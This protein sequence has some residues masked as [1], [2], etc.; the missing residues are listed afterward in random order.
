M[1]YLTNHF[2]KSMDKFGESE[3]GRGESFNDEFGRGHS[4]NNET[5]SKSHDSISDH[6]N[7]IISLEKEREELQKIAQD[8]NRIYSFKYK[9]RPFSV[10]KQYREKPVPIKV[11]KGIF[12]D[13]TKYAYNEY[14]YVLVADK[15]FNWSTDRY[16]KMLYEI[17]YSNENIIVDIITDKPNGKEPDGYDDAIDIPGSYYVKKH[18]FLS[19]YKGGYTSGKYRVYLSDALS[20]YK[21]DSGNYNYGGVTI[22]ELLRHIHP[23]GD[24]DKNSNDLK[25]WYRVIQ[26]SNLGGFQNR[27]SGI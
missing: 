8:L 15:S 1:L 12:R 26:G 3:F 10:E 24:L 11:E 25:A 14:V 2:K 4:H 21:P 16:T 13:T 20:E 17:I 7:H 9:A 6:T 18:G 23:N 22:H 27:N 5:F 19:N